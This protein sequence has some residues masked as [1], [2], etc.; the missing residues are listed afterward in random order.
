M[1]EKNK[2]AG[3]RTAGFWIL[4]IVSV[5][6]ALWFG[7]M[8]PKALTG[9]AVVASIVF[10][11]VLASYSTMFS[12]VS[13]S[14]W[15]AASVTAPMFYPEI[16]TTLHGFKLSRTVIPLIMFIMFGMGTT[17][18]IGDF[19]RVF[20]IPQAVL[21]GILLQYTVMPFTAK[22]VAMTFARGYDEVAAG[23]ILVGTAPG[24][25]ASNV[26]N[27]LANNNVALSVTMT[28]FS[29]LVSPFVSP[30]LTKFLAGAYIPVDFW[31]MMIAMM[32]MVVIPVGLGIFVNKVIRTLRE[33]HPGMIAVSNWIFR[34]LPLLAMAAICISVAI[35]TA[36]ARN[37]LLLGSVVVAILS[38]VIVHNVL[39][40]T[41]GYWG[42]RLFRLGEVNCR[43]I[44]IEV[45]MQNS[46]MAA[47]LA[48]SV[49][50]SPLAAVPGVVYS[51]W[52][53]ITGALLASWWRRH[54]P[55]DEP[56]TSAAP[57]P[58]VVDADA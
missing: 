53:N 7:F 26:I 16:F 58:A 32:K 15:M 23:V 34:S 29:T 13:F 40:L 25:V 24:G 2:P 5:A 31:A 52:H 1:S 37:Q 55:A 30:G 10:L 46:G 22:F 45:G 17:L 42:A 3:E 6:T 14:L 19:K 18:S 12:G 4:F 56:A 48:L 9:V 47:G 44:A 41:L 50:K 28:A 8:G 39:G 35:M 51:S 43:T 54:P 11:A 57:I 21:I 38:S 33:I 49:F 27:Y 36:S 20:L